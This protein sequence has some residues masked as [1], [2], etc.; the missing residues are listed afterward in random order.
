LIFYVKL[1]LLLL[2]KFGSS[3]STLEFFLTCN[4]FQTTLMRE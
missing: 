2:K 1:V 4:I 3:S